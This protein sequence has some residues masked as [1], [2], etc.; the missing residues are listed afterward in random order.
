MLVLL[1]PPAAGCSGGSNAGP[2]IRWSCF[3][4]DAHHGPAAGAGRRIETLEVP[5]EAVQPGDG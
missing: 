2:T 5:I 1:L 4:A 3:F